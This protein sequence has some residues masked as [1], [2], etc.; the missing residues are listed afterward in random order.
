MRAGAPRIDLGDPGLPRRLHAALAPLR[1][2]DPVHR[3]R[4]G[5][6]LLTRY[7]DVAEILKDRERCDTD[8]HARRGYDDERPFGAGT[9]LERFQEGLLVNLA[10]DDHRRV[11]AAFTAPFTRAAVEAGVAAVVTRRAA[12]LMDALPDDGEVDWVEA[13]A[14]PLPARVFAELFDLPFADL[15]W[16]LERL[17]EDTVAFDVLLDPALVG[18]E[19]LAR[20]QRAMLDLRTY[21]D[22]LAA[23]RLERPGRD[24]LSWLVS[25]YSDGRL[26]WDDV[27]TQAMEALAAG[28]ST[29]QTLLAA[30]LEVLAAHPDQW[31]A[32]ARDPEL[33]TPAVEEALRYVSPALA[34]G[35]IAVC[36][37]DLRGRAIAAGDLLQC[38]VLVANRDPEAFPDPDRFDVTRT[39]NRHLAFGGGAHTCLGAHVARLEGRVVL[40]RAVARWRR[41]EVDTA[42]TALHPTLMIRTFRT[43]PVRLVGR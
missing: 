4:D 41:I 38:A 35:R 32:V 24:L 10:A 36:D 31:E 23:A 17:H 28:T 18:P 34:M 25:G 20:G 8:I 14:Q 33:A 6:W 9:A 13:L 37:F 40:Q 27:L 22:A 19:A 1:E 43:M 2:R 42:A 3:L 21:L 39:P 16:L 12:E 29:T 11:R 15:A 7:D 30:M 5:T 26:S